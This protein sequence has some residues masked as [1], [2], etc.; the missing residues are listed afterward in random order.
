MLRSKLASSLM[1]V[2]ANRSFSTKPSSRRLTRKQ[3]SCR[4]EPLEVRQLLTG[5]FVWVNA[6]GST[7]SD[8]ATDVT[9]DSAGNVYT[10]GTFSGTVDFDPGSGVTN[11]TSP[12]GTTGMF[13]TKVN[14]N[15]VLIWARGLLVGGGFGSV[16][17]ASIAVD[18]AGNVLTTGAFSATVDF[19][20]GVGVT[21]ISSSLDIDAFVSKLDSSGNFVWAKSVGGG[22]PSVQM[23]RGTG[24]AVDSTG[25]VY[26]AGF[27]TG[28]A[29]FDPG[30]GTTQLVSAG[31]NDVFVWKLNSAGI[32]QWARRMGGEGVILV[33]ASRSTLSAMF[34][35]RAT[36]TGRLIS[37]QALVFA[38]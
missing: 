22:G 23:D 30:S 21:N 14:S 13:V 33:R 28:T 32:F 34:T 38:S 25:N 36:S 3:R 19:D 12:S 1:Q 8:Q 17:P 6:V 27:F 9:T 18:S 4:T 16:N 24:I 5:D 15:G 35:R 7:G 29:D 20:P 2:V 26:T 31:L 37:I 11:L 10:T